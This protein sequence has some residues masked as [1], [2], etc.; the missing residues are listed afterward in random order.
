MPIPPKKPFYRKRFVKR[1]PSEIAQLEAANTEDAANPPEESNGEVVNLDELRT[2]HI[3]ALVKM[4]AA[5]GVGNPARLRK[6]ELL[7]AMLQSRARQGERIYG[8]GTL[9]VIPDGYGF[10]RFPDQSY[11][12]GAGDIYVSPNQIRQHSI[13]TGDEI[14]GSVRTPR[15]NERYFALS[16]P[17]KINGMPVGEAASNK[18]LF[19]NLTPLFPS[20]M[21]TLERK[22][23]AEENITGRIID[24]ISPIGKG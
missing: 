10:L 15:D 14:S 18:I 11:A 3:G 8:K 21:F 1:M 19:E 2:M 23:R 6:Q 17:E 9:E 16:R 12:A 4:A 24:I 7:F 5:A 13:V 20:E 22:L